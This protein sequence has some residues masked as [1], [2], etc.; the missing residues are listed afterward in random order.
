[1]PPNAAHSVVFYV[2]QPREDESI[3]SLVDRIGALHRIDRDAVAMALLARSA[4]SGPH[5]WLVDWDNPPLELLRLLEQSIGLSPGALESHR[6]HDGPTWLVSAYR[7][8]YCPACF[9]AD[10][11][12]GSFPYFRRQWAKVY[13]TM[14]SVHVAPLCLWARGVWSWA[15]RELPFDWAAATDRSVL[16]A[17]VKPGWPGTGLAKA[18]IY[19]EADLAREI[20]LHGDISAVTDPRL[21]EIGQVILRVALV[22]RTGGAEGYRAKPS[23]GLLL[24][25]VAGWALTSKGAETQIAGPAHGAPWV[26]FRRVMNPAE[27]RAAIFVTGVTLRWDLP[28]AAIEPPA[29]LDRDIDDLRQ[30]IL[31]PRVASGMYLRRDQRKWERRGLECRETAS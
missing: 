1:M 5:P 18:L 23:A 7:Q 3:S 11:A 21:R 16:V 31:W 28:L 14:C 6:I 29:A 10:I 22:L 30:R 9:R 13:T 26:R 2:E 17:G 12:A 20:E 8:S 27:R 24:A 19:C 4:G 15:G 25:T